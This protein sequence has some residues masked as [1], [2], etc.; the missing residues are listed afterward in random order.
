MARAAGTP[1]AAGGKTATTE[2]VEADLKRKLTAS[3]L[4][5]E[6]LRRELATARSLGKGAISEAASAAAKLRELEAAAERERNRYEEARAAT[7]ALQRELRNGRVEVQTAQQGEQR[8]LQEQQRLEA[9]LGRTRQQLQ[10]AQKQPQI[11]PTPPAAPRPSS[12]APREHQ[13]LQTRLR[14]AEEDLAK[15]QVIHPYRHTPV[16]VYVHG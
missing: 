2:M 5:V 6:S 13:Q 12:G 4:E 10:D 15:A 16:Y 7:E 14:L 11:I 3:A 1:I 9:E 8:A